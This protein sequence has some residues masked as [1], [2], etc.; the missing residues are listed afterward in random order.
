MIFFLSTFNFP[1]LGRIPVTI[2]NILFEVGQ[3]THADF[4]KIFLNGLVFYFKINPLLFILLFILILFA[5][6]NII[7]S[8][9]I[10]LKI[11]QLLSLLLFF[12]TMIYSFREYNLSSGDISDIS[13][14]FRNHFIYIFFVACIFFN[15]EISEKIKKYKKYL[16]ILGIAIFLSNIIIYENLRSDEIRRY[17]Q[18][19]NLF[20]YE[21]QKF[22]KIKNIYLYKSPKFSFNEILLHYSSNDSNSGKLFIKEIEE[23]NNK[24]S[25]LHIDDVIFTFEKKEKINKFKTL[26]FIYDYESFLQRNFTNFFYNSLSF[27]SLKNNNNLIFNSSRTRNLLSKNFHGKALLAYPTNSILISRYKDKLFKHIENNFTVIE[28]KEVSILNDNWLFI[29]IK[30]K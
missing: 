23:R 11:L 25:W 29:V 1:I 10:S 7:F 2:F 21:L 17:H 5:F 18:K 6:Y 20:N 13:F 22:D 16:M 28:F 4:L 24:Y 9:I 14:V 15:N 30:N 26:S 12:Y 3:T 19:K 27:F 8:K